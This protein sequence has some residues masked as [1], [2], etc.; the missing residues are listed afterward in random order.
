MKECSDGK[1]KS[2]SEL[3][4]SHYPYPPSFKVL[5]LV[6]AELVVRCRGGGTWTFDDELRNEKG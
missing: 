2:T 3:A 4:V 1:M 5:T 6:V